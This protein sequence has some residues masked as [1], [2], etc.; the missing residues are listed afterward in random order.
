M[1]CFDV[2]CFA[3]ISDAGVGA[4]PEHRGV[5]EQGEEAA[6]AQGATSGE[7]AEEAKGRGEEGGVGGVL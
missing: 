4:V 1:I 5:V 6:A 7:N 2:I 3:L